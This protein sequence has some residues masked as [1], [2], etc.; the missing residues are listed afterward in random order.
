MIE[1]MS[2]E[3]I[4]GAVGGIA[5]F[6]LKYI[7]QKEANIQ[8]AH[9]RALELMAGIDA[10]ASNAAQRDNS[11]AGQWTRRIIVFCIMFAAIGALFIMPLI[12]VPVT[13]EMKESTSILFGLWEWS[14]PIFVD[15]KGYLLIPEHRQAFIALIFFY[16]GSGIVGSTKASS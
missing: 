10:S 5:G 6:V 11:T 4:S 8:A 12:N 3:L 9:T 14:Q 2:A 13:V 15:V 1:W 16:F 7:A